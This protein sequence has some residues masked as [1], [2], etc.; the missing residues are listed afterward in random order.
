M[1]QCIPTRKL[2]YVYAQKR[3]CKQTDVHTYVQIYMLALVYAKIYTSKHAYI[4]MRTFMY[5]Q[6]RPYMCLNACISFLL[7]HEQT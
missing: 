2:I 3:A 4:Y 5:A 6:M 7:K 1:H